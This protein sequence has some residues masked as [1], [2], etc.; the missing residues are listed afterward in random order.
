M[1]RS[2]FLHVIERLEGLV[3][4]LPVTIQKPILSELTP[5]KEL[6]LKQRSPR[7]AFTGSA[8]TPLPRIMAAIFPD[9][10]PADPGGTAHRKDHWRD[11]ALHD[12]G[13]ISIL[14]IRGAELG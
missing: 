1:N 13:A 5:L 4:R 10:V 8:N 7:F 14:D 12:R 11:Y 3:G 2:L 9:F 6:F